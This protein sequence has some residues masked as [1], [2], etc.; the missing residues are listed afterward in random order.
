MPGRLTEEHRAKCRNYYYANREVC[1]ER[2]RARNKRNWEQVREYQKA[3]YEANRERIRERERLKYSGQAIVKAEPKP[4]VEGP[5]EL[6]KIS[7][8]K[9]ENTELE[10]K[11][12]VP[13]PVKIERRPE[14]FC[15]VFN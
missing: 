13:A 12:G 4:V 10:V 11:V 9:S 14:D 6:K 8:N 1:I 3:Y 7:K 15:I 2:V 5:K